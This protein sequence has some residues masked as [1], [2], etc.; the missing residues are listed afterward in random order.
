MKTILFLDG[1]KFKTKAVEKFIES[2]FTKE[3]VTF[4]STSKI[5]ML[6]SITTSTLD[7]VIIGDNI[8]I[9]SISKYPQGYYTPHFIYNYI[10]AVL[11]YSPKCCLFSNNHDYT[12][13]GT[14]DDKLHENCKSNNIPY[15]NNLDDDA[16]SELFD[17][18]NTN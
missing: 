13:F 7:L 18:I 4:L 5:S 2:N 6:S 1:S 10:A 17:F 12:L 9:T 11:D 8:D 3:E 16:F 14:T 15:I